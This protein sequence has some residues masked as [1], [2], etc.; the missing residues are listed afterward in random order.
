MGRKFDQDLHALIPGQLLV[1]I[2]IGLVGFREASEALELFFHQITI[3]R[4]NCFPSKN[5][6]IS[7][8][9][10]HDR[11]GRSYRETRL[12]QEKGKRDGNE[13]AA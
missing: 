12:A 3:S 7:R 4:A 11:A 13:S 1:E 9:L 8:P 10:E 2:A 5:H 6:E